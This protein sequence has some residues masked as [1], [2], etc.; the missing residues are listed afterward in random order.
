MAY[1][2]HPPVNEQARNY[3]VSASSLVHRDPPAP[4]YA[5]LMDHELLRY[6]PA[7][8]DYKALLGRITG[9]VDAARIAPVHDVQVPSRSMLALPS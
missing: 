3:S 6:R 1:S 4:R 8:N 5:L 9:L 2:V 7:N